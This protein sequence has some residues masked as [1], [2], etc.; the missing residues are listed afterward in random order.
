[1]IQNMA[2]IEN[3][4]RSRKGI[5]LLTL[6]LCIF[7]LALILFIMLL[8]VNQKTRETHRKQQEA[9]EHYVLLTQEAK[10]LESASDYLTEQVRAFAATGDRQYVD[11]YFEET[12]VTR[13][14]D[15]ALAV[16]EE[17][18][19][20]TYSFRY[21]KEALEDSGE[22][23]EIEYY[24]MCLVIA[25]R[26]YDMDEYPEKLREITLSAKDQ[27]L[28]TTFKAAKAESLLYDQTY[29]DYKSSIR[30]NISR[31][32]DTMLEM[33]RK[34]QVDSSERLL[35]ML[36]LQSLLCIL[37]LLLVALT[38]VCNWTMI[39]RPLQKISAKIRRQEP[40]PLTGA[41]ELQFLE[42]TYNVMFEEN[43][44]NNDRLSFDATH[45][46][47][48]GLYN[49]GVFERERMAAKRR[50][51]ALILI[52]VDCFKGINDTYG[53]D[54]GDRILKKVAA[55]L[56]ENFRSE[57]FVCRIGGDEFAVIMVH[58]TPDMK[59]ILEQKIAITRQTLRNTDDGLPQITLS[60]GIA[61]T[62]HD[63]PDSDIFKNADS[64]LYKVKEAGRN[65]LA[66][67]EPGGQV[68]RHE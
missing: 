29:Q 24:A 56:Q 23:E 62:D 68:P 39:L 11:L 5:R 55:S 32:T 64:A 49:R 2:A 58:T 17:D 35:K 47:L 40:L 42:E 65:G 61:F 41:S 1:M 60:V 6:N 4:D 27:A 52:D 59:S 33:T 28:P 48:T 31:C 3:T 34:D 26:N 53:H 7:L 54:V 66:F 14:R 16:I 19:S 51:I 8:L 13:R 43:Q 22:L 57:D 38:V 37:M 15:T 21:M 25:S 44:K 45:D 36:Q 9:V 50:K 12:E 46:A 20:D 67:Y 18:M 63:D 10:T 30:E